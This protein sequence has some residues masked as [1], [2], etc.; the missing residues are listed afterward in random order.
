M[1]L[2]NKP[3]RTRY[4]I[5]LSVLIVLFI[6]VFISSFFIG[7]FSVTPVTTI[8]I[9]L[10]RII[11]IKQTWTDM[12]YSVVINLRLPRIA[13]AALI[14]A[15]LSVA[16]CVYQGMFRNPMASPDILG[17]SA[18]AGFGAALG[19]VLGA[20]YFGISLIAFIFGLI[21]VLITYTISRKSKM[22]TTIALLLAGVMVGSL[23]QS[24][25]NLLKMLADSENQLPAITYWL[26]G[27]LAS[28]QH[29]DFIV[30]LIP[31]LVGLIPIFLLRWRINLLTVS[32]AEAQSLGVETNKL[33]FVVIICATLMTSASVAIA[34][35]IGWVGLVVPYFCRLLFDEDFRHLI[36]ASA[37]FGA[38]FLMVVDTI[39]RAVATSEIPVGIITSFIGAPL[40]I[41]LIISGGTKNASKN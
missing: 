17:T 34:G 40:F 36:P 41:F 35:T 25:T 28:V 29:S 1:E 10:S 39:A 15:A 11:P 22:Q 13:C 9:L 21:A 38:L 3:E 26:M 27:S 5:K 7:R 6:F 2:R 12:Q 8:K 30:V 16:G 4:S 33:R 23:F 19:I 24:G 14:G 20:S 37:L 31:V 32:E 18:G